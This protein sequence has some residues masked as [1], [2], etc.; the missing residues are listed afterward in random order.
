MSDA[1]DEDDFDHR[2]FLLDQIEL[3]VRS[4]FGAEEDILGELE[5][6]VMGYYD[7]YGLGEPEPTL[8]A[9]LR[10]HA[11]RLLQ[12][13]RDREAGWT[14]PTVNDAIDRAFEELNAKSIVALQNA[15]YTQSDGW[16]DTNE[17]ASNLPSPPRGGT[18]Y[19]GQDL[20]RGVMGEGLLLTFGAYEEDESKR[21]AASLAVARDI[22]ETLARHGVKTEWNGSIDER[23]AIP[24]FEWRKRRWTRVPASGTR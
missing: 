7:D 18:F 14:G 12:E 9:E 16:D 24:P 1:Y 20:E 5:Q 11:Q 22:C 17:L 21:E 8:V 4:G 15:G 13:Q 2:Q 10:A 6:N 3:E 23:I 19:Q